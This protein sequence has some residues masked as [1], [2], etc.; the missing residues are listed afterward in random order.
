MSRQPL[1]SHRFGPLLQLSGVSVVETVDAGPVGVGNGTEERADEADGIVELALTKEGIVT[2]V[3]LNDEDP[4]QKEGV[5]HTQQQGKP[6]RIAYAE[7]HR[8][9]QGQKRTEAAKELAYGPPGIGLLVLGDDGFPVL[10]GLVDLIHPI[11]NIYLHA[12]SF[13]GCLSRCGYQ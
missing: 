9:P 2:A 10:Q 5:D 7:V 6:D 4:H 11:L 13:K 8:H 12:S 3:V 1:L